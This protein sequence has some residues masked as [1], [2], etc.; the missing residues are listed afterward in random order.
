MTF[1]SFSDT[2]FVIK[3]SRAAI[4]RSKS[5]R[6]KLRKIT[7]DTG[8]EEGDDEGDEE[9]DDVGGAKREK[10]SKGKKKVSLTKAD[11]EEM[12][13]IGQF[14][15]GFILARDHRN[16]NLWILDQHGCDEIKN[17]ERLVRDTR[18]HEQRLLAPLQ[19]E[20]R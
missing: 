12:E 20:L 6:R 8:E 2:A 14:N 10:A 3:S 18:I 1:V 7:D 15:L 11:F 4:E 17:F 5:I 19:L 9:E 13:I 16:Q